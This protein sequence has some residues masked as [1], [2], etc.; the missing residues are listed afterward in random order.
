SALEMVKNGHGVVPPDS[1][2]RYRHPHLT[3]YGVCSLLAQ[4]V[5]CLLCLVYTVS[6]KVSMTAF[7]VVFV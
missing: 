4:P 3:Q 1:L 6:I 7:Y 5:C 2:I